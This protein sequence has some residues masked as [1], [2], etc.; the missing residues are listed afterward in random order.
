MDMLKRIVRHKVIYL[1]LLIVAVITV[2]V[3]NSDEASANNWQDTAYTFYFSVSQNATYVASSGRTKQ[4]TSK[5]YIMC[6]YAYE[7]NVSGS[8]RF[9]AQAHG[10][11]NS[12]SGFAACTYNGHST[13]TYTIYKNTSKYMTNYIRETN[14]T[15]ANI[16]VSKNGMQATFKGDWSPDN[17]NCY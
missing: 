10:S 5:V 11:N 16:Y 4:D 7:P 2:A 8:L 17:Y 14:K 15:Y 9:N 13:P 6:N 12:S 3:V 1:A